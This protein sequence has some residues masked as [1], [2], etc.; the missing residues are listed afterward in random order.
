MISNVDFRKLK[1]ELIFVPLGGS[2]QIGMNLNLY[3]YNGKWI[4][5]DLGLGFADSELPGIDI[6]IPNITIIKDMHITK[7]K[8]SLRNKIPNEQVTKGTK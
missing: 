3:H 8:F 4:I 1:N 6:I 7:V 2:G 5:I